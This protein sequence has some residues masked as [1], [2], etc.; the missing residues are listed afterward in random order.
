MIVLL[1]WV[2]FFPFGW[3]GRGA[4]LK[5]LTCACVYV[6][7]C[8]HACQCVCLLCTSRYEWICCGV[9]GESEVVRRS[10]ARMYDT[11]GV[12]VHVWTLFNYLSV[13]VLV[14][15]MHNLGRSFR[16]GVNETS[17]LAKPWT[18]ISS[19]CNSSVLSLCVRVPPLIWSFISEVLYA[20]L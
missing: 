13:I 9:V 20:W 12:C 18:L 7:V 14:T 5:F 4:H 17:A 19:L 15:M 2:F 8:V 16:E 3:G 1:Y 11:S 6:C 10:T